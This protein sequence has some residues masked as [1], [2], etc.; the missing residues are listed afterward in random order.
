[1]NDEVIL[2]PFVEE[3]FNLAAAETVTCCGCET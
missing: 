3:Q 1:M 2:Q